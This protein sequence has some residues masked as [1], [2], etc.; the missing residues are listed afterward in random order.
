MS[1][2]VLAKLAEEIED[3]GTAYILLGVKGQV[4]RDATTPRRH[5]ESTNA[6]DL[7]V[8]AFAHDKGGGLSTGRPGSADQGGHHEPRLVDADQTRLEAGEFFLARVHS[9]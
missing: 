5:D 2:V 6:R 3:L 1:R 7:L 8:G 4:E 9:F